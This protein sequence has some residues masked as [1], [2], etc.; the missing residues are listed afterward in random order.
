MDVEDDEIK[1]SFMKGPDKNETY[2]WPDR[3]EATWRKKSN[4]R[5]VLPKP[6]LATSSTNDRQ[7]Y[8]FT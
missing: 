6:Q 5:K 4:I 1:L 8:V 7:S 2:K 3:E